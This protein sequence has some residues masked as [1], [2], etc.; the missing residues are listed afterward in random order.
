MLLSSLQIEKTIF[1][2]FF[3][4][5]LIK[6]DAKLKLKRKGMQLHPLGESYMCRINRSSYKM[7]MLIIFNLAFEIYLFFCAM[8]FGNFAVRQPTSILN[9]IQKNE[10]YFLFVWAN[11]YLVLCFKTCIATIRWKIANHLI[12]T[13]QCV[14]FEQRIKNIYAN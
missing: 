14:F 2:L 13:P 12:E 7:N 1:E 3:F 6:A 9:S 11:R 8:Y 4:I 5:G 10:N